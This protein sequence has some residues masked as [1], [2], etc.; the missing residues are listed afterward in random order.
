MIS[1]ST[2]TTMTVV[3]SRV[4]S[5]PFEDRGDVDLEAL[6][7]RSADAHAVADRRMPRL[8]APARGR[9]GLRRP[10]RGPAARPPGRRC[11]HPRP[12]RAGRSRRC[13][14][15]A[16]SP[17]ALASIADE[18]LSAELPRRPT[19]RPEARRCRRRSANSSC[20]FSTC[21]D[22][23]DVREPDR[24]CGIALLTTAQGEQRAGGESREDEDDPR[25]LCGRDESE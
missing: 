19:R 6:R 12:G 21:T 3:S 4:K 24:R 1:S 14:R 8:A 23:A 5:A 20:S 9:P 18:C 10:A 25:R 15:S 11:R 17:N 7:R 2:A 22:S 16:R 13:E